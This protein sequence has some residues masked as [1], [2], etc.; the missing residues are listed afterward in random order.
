MVLLAYPK[1]GRKVRLS[2]STYPILGIASV[3]RACWSVTFT[4]GTKSGLDRS[5]INPVFFKE[6]IEYMITTTANQAYI[7][8]IL[9]CFL[10]HTDTKEGD[11]A[12]KCEQEVVKNLK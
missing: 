2:I 7:D 8:P 12:T 6:L 11:Y 1:L 4:V 5:C 9:L 10:T 3:E